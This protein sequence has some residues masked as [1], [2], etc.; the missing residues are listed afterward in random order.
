MIKFLLCLSLIVSSDAFGVEQ[1][2]ID[3]FISNNVKPNTP[4]CISICSTL[5]SDMK[6]FFC[7]TQCE[8]YCKDYC[9]KI[10]SDLEKKIKSNFPSNWPRK[11]NKSDWS[12]SASQ[13]TVEALTKVPDLF[14]KDEK[15]D[16]YRMSKS[17]YDGNPASTSVERPYSIVLYDTAFTNRFNLSR[18][19]VHEFA[20][21]YYSKL[22]SELKDSYNLKMNWFL[23]DSRKELWISRRD[24]FVA[25]DGKLSPE[26]DFANNIEYF[27]FDKAILQ[28]KSKNAYDWILQ[29]F[30]ALKLNSGCKYEK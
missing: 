24:G 14:V 30:K 20:H 10:I 17:I 15:F 13:M 16:V 27:L 3:F 7:N 19:L 18:V 11:E 26:E 5:K 6:T 29:N 25:E 4:T 12:K 9:K 23:I 2:C 1:D 21:L 22:S 28:T 8:A